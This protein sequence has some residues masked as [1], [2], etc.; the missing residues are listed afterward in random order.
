MFD[1]RSGISTRPIL[2]R[3]EIENI[4]TFNEW[5]HNHRPNHRLKSPQQQDH[6][7]FNYGLLYH[8]ACCMR[9]SS[10]ETQQIAHQSTASICNEIA[11]NN[12]LSVE[13]KPKQGW[14][15]CRLPES[16]LKL[17]DIQSD[18]QNRCRFCTMQYLK[19]R[20]STQALKL[21][22]FLFLTFV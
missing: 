8:D 18:V 3:I 13:I 20:A 10:V 1:G 22:F 9:L 6:F 21:F 19:V 2:V 12:V 17:M 4:D 16:L 15:I 7:V 11:A 14:N 5:L